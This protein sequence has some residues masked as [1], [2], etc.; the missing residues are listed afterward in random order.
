MTVDDN[1]LIEVLLDNAPD[2]IYMLDEKGNYI[3]VNSVYIQITHMTRADLLKCNIYDFVR[4]K[5]VDICISDIVYREKRRVCMFQEIYITGENKHYRQLVISTPVFDNDGNVCNIIAF[6]RP[7]NAMND[8]YNQAAT[9]A[10]HSTFIS[11]EVRPSVGIIA[12]SSMMKSLLSVAK[13]IA[14]VDSAVL[15]TGESGTGK[16]VMAEYIHRSGARCKNPMVIIN[17]ASLPPNL[18]EAELFGYEK[19]A[20]TGASSTGKIGLFE[21][22][23]GG[24]LLLDEINSLPLSLQGKLLRVIG[25]R[26]VQR[27]GSTKELMVDFRLIAATNEELSKLVENKQFRADLYYRL[28]VI[29][30]TIPPLRARRDDIIPLVLHFLKEYCDKYSKNKLFTE[31]TLNLIY[32]YDWPGNVRELKNFIERSVVMSKDD[33]IEISDIAN[34]SGG[35]VPERQ[36]EMTH[37]QDPKKFDYNKLL[38]EGVTLEDHLRA[39]EAEYVKH[40]LDVYKSSYL[41]A[42]ALGTSQSAIMRRKKKYQFS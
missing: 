1:R 30:I 22:A 6:V 29:P 35:Y 32:Q 34:I 27:I 8:Y 24:T 5:L 15:I 3:Y 26:H 10:S 33:Y 20:F 39:C 2:G 14:D 9:H 19:G 16:E 12:E 37:P 11:S 40:A 42:K 28:N 18:M 13:T 23:N 31:Q 7:L 21:K 4:D 17:C 25:S 41:T 38:E 36:N